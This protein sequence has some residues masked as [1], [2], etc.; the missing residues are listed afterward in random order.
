M[1]L[2][3]FRRGLPELRG[4]TSAGLDFGL[5]TA[6]LHAYQAASVTARTHARSNG[7]GGSSASSQDALVEIL[8]GGPRWREAVDAKGGSF[9]AAW[10]RAGEEDA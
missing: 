5:L 3:F 4:R 10:S 1:D 2:G 6:S 8:L 9:N 7:R